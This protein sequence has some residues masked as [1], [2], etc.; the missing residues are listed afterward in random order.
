MNLIWIYRCPRARRRRWCR[1]ES[2]GAAI[3]GAV[4]GH[5][6]EVFGAARRSDGDLREGQRPAQFSAALLQQGAV[7]EVQG[8]LAPKS[9]LYRDAEELYLK[10]LRVLGSR[11]CCGA[12]SVWDLVCWELSCHLY[13]KATLLY[14]HSKDPAEIMESF[15]HALKY[16]QLSP[17]PR[18]YLYQFRAAMIHTRLG[19][20]YHAQYRSLS[21]DN[22]GA[23]RRALMTLAQRAR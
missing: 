18:Q 3:P 11:E 17:G 21:P 7:Y 23:K 8:P 4:H 5:V 19:S 2:N 22:D 14:E 20:L 10:S 16:C 12:A 1:R 13:T 9:S 6:E 15:K